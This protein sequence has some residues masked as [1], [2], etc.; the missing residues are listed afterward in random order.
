MNIAQSAFRSAAA[1]GTLLFA[2]ECRVSVEQV[3][4]A[5]H[6]VGTSDGRP[7]E[8]GPQDTTSSAAGPYR[9][10]HSL[11]K[12][13]TL[14]VSP[15]RRHRY[16]VAFYRMHS[17]RLQ[18]SFVNYDQ[19]VL[20]DHSTSSNFRRTYML[21]LSGNDMMGE[22]CWLIYICKHINRERAS[23]IGSPTRHEDRSWV[24]VWHRSIS[25]SDTRVKHG[26]IGALT[27]I[28]VTLC[29]DAFVY[30]RKSCSKTVL[31]NTALQAICSILDY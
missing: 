5:T 13:S 19:I 24:Y 2:F 3:G 26:S 16:M 8:Y 12:P 10:R 22:P 4:S 18:F 17:Y 28:A 23:E 30:K 15:G 29:A 1:D 25:H 11:S 31:R 27:S 9:P 20:D 21:P 7:S 14:W 6:S